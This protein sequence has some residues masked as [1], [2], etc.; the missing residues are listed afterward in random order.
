[1]RYVVH[2]EGMKIHTKYLLENGKRTDLLGDLRLD[3][4]STIKI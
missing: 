3:E 4:E 1:M 2:M